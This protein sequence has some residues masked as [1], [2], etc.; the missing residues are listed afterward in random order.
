MPVQ[1]YSS[2][3]AVDEVHERLEPKLREE[4]VEYLDNISP[5]WIRLSDYRE[6]DE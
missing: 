5:D 3:M 1:K 4:L 6:L 2:E